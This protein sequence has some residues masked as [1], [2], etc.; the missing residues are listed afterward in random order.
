MIRAQPIRKPELTAPAAGARISVSRA[1]RP[2][3]HLVH[4]ILQRKCACAGAPAGACRSRVEDESGFQR[5]LS[6]GS[7]SDPLEREADR[8]ADQV[9]AR[10]GAAAIAPAPVSVRRFS[11]A[12]S[13]ATNAAPPSVEHA[14]AG[15]GQPLDRAT[16]SVM[17]QRF[18]HD[19]SS[20][21]I[22]DD[23]AARQSARDVGAL[24]YTA[25]NHVVFAPGQYAA[26]TSAGARLLAHELV[27]VVQQRGGTSPVVQRACGPAALG[28]PAPDCSPS[29]KGVVGWQLRFKVNCDEL[30]PG[31]EAKLSQ[32][33]AGSANEVHGFASKEGPA[34]FNLDLSCHRANRIAEL[35]G[36]KRPDC[37]V[38]GRFKHGG[39]P[40][41]APGLVPDSNPPGA[42]RSVIVQNSMPVAGPDQIC[43]PD[44]TPW[45]LGQIA[46]AKADPRVLGVGQSLALAKIFAPFISPNA[47]LDAIDML[48]GELA[49]KTAAAWLAAGKPRHTADANAQL[50]EPSAVLGRLEVQTAKMAA[51]TMD[52]NAIV[53][54]LALRDAALAWKALVGHGK[55]FDFK[56]D[57]ATMGDPRSASC[58]RG[59]SNT[60]TLCPGNTGKNCYEK[61]LPGNVFYAHIGVYAGFSENALQL[62]SQYAQLTSPSKQGRHWDPPADTQMIS[63]GANLPMAL[64]AS[65]FCAAL[66]G[67]KGSFATHNCADCTEAPAGIATK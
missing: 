27:H 7:S 60:I 50:G 48:E 64:T 53:T 6:V 34:A 24:A 59:C 23:S 32:I 13:A 15:A 3:P 30:L 58:P 19:F 33:K 62:G 38:A 18:G 44:A 52:P 55:P 36:S 43:G 25:G 1:Q 49:N 17:E 10:P 41:S 16:R 47:K 51:V 28:T 12:Q 67:A 31:E 45:F 61:D 5:K 46:S 29:D 63:F 2:N 66:Q 37:T 20:V 8:I 35:I 56:V 22:H 9:L 11:G 4:A 57:P 39:S 14:L 26:R 54:L 65:T 42:W 40:V 21:R